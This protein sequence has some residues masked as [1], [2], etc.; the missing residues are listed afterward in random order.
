MKLLIK[1]ITLIAVVGLS[2]C[3]GDNEGDY[4]PADLVN[5]PATASSE[6]A[7][8]RMP[9]MVFENSNQDFGT[10]VQGTSVTHTF[11]FTN[12]GDAD[13]IISFAKG[14]CGCTIPEWPKRPI[15]P[16]QSG[17]IT[18]VFNS[19]GKRDA[20]NKKVNITANT[21]PT[22]NVIALK[23]IVVAPENK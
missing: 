23:G 5:N 22:I 16:G 13:L 20:Q 3:G 10:I 19:Q 17:E 18:V 21:K 11:K 14:S 8:E 1:S 9:K 6:K 4:L 12:E 15:K 2:A 7:D